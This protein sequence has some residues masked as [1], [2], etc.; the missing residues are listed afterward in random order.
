MKD[1]VAQAVEDKMAM[2]QESPEVSSKR[3][4]L[5]R[6]LH[7]FNY[8]NDQEWQDLTNPR[9][10]LETKLGTLASRFGAIGLTCPSEPTFV[11]ANA[12]LHVALHNAGPVEDIKV[13]SRKAFSILQD[14]EDQEIEPQ[15]Y[16][17]I[18]ARPVRFGPGFLEHGLQ[19]ET[20]YPLP[21]GCGSYQ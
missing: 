17:I 14:Q 5:Q 10:S 2:K 9:L 16:Y 19:R 1:E 18:P 15:R 4:P 21:L 11:L 3:K 8:L 7:L 12:V 6:N 20:C 13:D